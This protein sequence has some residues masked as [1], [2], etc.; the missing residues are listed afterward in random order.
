M[1]WVLLQIFLV[2]PSLVQGVGAAS[3]FG[4]AAGLEE[5]PSLARQP[6]AHLTA[7][8]RTLQEEV[9]SNRRVPS[10]AHSAQLP[11]FTITLNP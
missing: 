1:T 2:Q 9:V 5:L 10:R 8:S 11:I 7:S 4:A 3:V 6:R